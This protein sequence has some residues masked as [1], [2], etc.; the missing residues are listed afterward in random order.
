MVLV[1][2]GGNGGR[3]GGSV[4]VKE[5]GEGWVLS[6]IGVGRAGSGWVLSSMGGVGAE[7]G[8]GEGFGGRAARAWQQQRRGDAGF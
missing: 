6:S 2:I 1:F 8:D 3:R 7:L 5:G 4:T